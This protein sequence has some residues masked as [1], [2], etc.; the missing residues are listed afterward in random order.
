MP[1]RGKNVPYLGTR[2]YHLVGGCFALLREVLPDL[3][4]ATAVPDVVEVVVG[5]F[6]VGLG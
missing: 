1:T 2:A 3:G 5:M 6:F 4:T